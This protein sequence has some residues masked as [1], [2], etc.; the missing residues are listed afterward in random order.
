MKAHPIQLYL[1]FTLYIGAAFADADE[2]QRAR[3]R[4]ELKPHIDQL[5]AAKERKVAKNAILGALDT[6]HIA[7][8]DG[9]RPEG[10]WES[11]IKRM[12]GLE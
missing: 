7:M 8:P 3:L 1:P 10:D 4:T 5:R 2:A 9:W 11:Q 6:V 12:M